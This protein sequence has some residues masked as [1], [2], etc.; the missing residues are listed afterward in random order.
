[1]RRHSIRA[2]LACLGLLAWCA[3]AAGSAGQAPPDAAAEVLSIPSSYAVSLAES[4]LH[5][6]C[7]RRAPVR[8]FRELIAQGAEVNAVG[9]GG[10]SPMHACARTCS[11]CIPVLAAAGGRLDQGDDLGRTP[12]EMGLDVSRLDTVEALLRAGAN[13]NVENRDGNSAYMLALYRNPRPEMIALME[14]FGGRLTLMQRIRHL[15]RRL[16]PSNLIP[17]P[18][19]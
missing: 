12:L 7:Y 13:P 6:A 9:G 19:M 11:E 16:E 8:L 14:R 15:L 5:T 17:I 18:R 1:M 10:E 3:S 4:I 2:G